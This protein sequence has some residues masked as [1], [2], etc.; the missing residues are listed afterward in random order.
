MKR[1]GNLYHK[2]CSYE[3]LLAAHNNAKKGKSHYKEV[4]MIN[5]NPEKFLKNLEWML[6]NEAYYVNSN[7]YKIE[8]IIDKGK[9]RELKKLSYYPHRIVQWA[10][11]NV[12]EDIMLKNLIIDTYAS[13]R[14]RG[15]H[16]AS[17]RIKKALKDTENT[18]YCLKID[19]K[20][21]YPNVDNDILFSLLEHKFKDPQLLRLLKIIIFS[22]G[23]KGQPIG[24]LWS[25]FAGNF[26]LS[27][28]DHWIKE[29]KKIKYY[30]RYCDDIV[31]LSKDKEFLH[32]LK[33]ELDF[34]LDIN[35]KLKIKENWQ[36]FPV[37]SRGIDF[38]GYRFFRNFVLLRKRILKNFKKKI[39]KLKKKNILTFSENSSLNSYSGWLKFCNSYRLRKKYLDQF[40]EKKYLDK[41]GCEIKIKI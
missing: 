28:V 16:L 39:K 26:Y 5:K 1:Y 7:D 2:I 33:K 13:V 29:N 15:I 30:F 11:M 34:F 10:I 9:E 4:R 3:N 32:N 35:L 6:V 38:L 22:V 37:D 24:S 8:K 14:G 19:I 31:I 41:N 36:V 23:Q 20:K 12:I 40:K 17:K 25:Q 27:G 18:K 21:F